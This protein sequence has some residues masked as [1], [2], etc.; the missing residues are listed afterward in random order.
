MV[1]ILI[2]VRVN[3]KWF[4]HNLKPLSKIYLFILATTYV[5]RKGDTQKGEITNGEGVVQISG[6]SKHIYLQKK[7]PF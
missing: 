4:M 6:Q 2:Q 1:Y 7:Y 5:Y 3:L